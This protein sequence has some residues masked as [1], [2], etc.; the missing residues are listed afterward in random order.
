MDDQLPSP[1]NPKPPAE[2][3][4]LNARL[5]AEE[6][7]SRQTMIMRAEGFSGPLPPP[8]IL[9]NYDRIQPGL[10]DRL[11]KLAE[12]EADDRRSMEKTALNAQVAD[13]RQVNNEARCGQ[14][15]ALAITLVSLGVGGYTAING[16][17]IAGS[18]LGVGGI[19]GIVTTFILG[20]Q[21]QHDHSSDEPTEPS[22]KLEKSSRNKKR[23]R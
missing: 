21:R 18:I 23:K 22:P 2:A 6:R 16:H 9:A 10:A 3:E 20:R 15:C 4:I 13:A 12:S 8:E 11:V 1:P 7:Q 17:E 14:I 19:G 5:T